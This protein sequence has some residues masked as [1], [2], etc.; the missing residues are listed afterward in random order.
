MKHIYAIG[1]VA[2]EPMLAHKA[3]YEGKVAVEVIAG[4]PAAVRRRAPSRPWSSPIRKSP[5]AA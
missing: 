1:D 4:E 5:G 2:G 3:T